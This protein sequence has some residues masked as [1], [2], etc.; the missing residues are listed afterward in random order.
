MRGDENDMTKDD[1]AKANDP[2]QFT[3][4]EPAALREMFA[5]SK[6]QFT[7]MANKEGAE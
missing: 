3:I 5:M 2:A 1:E 4:K 7:E 6:K